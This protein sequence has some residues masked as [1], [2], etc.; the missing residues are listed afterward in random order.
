M[1]ATVRFLSTSGITT[2][3]AVAV[4][5]SD[6][7][8]LIQSSGLVEDYVSGNLSTYYHT[9]T[10]SAKPGIYTFTIAPAASVCPADFDIFI[11][12]TSTGDPVGVAEASFDDA[13]AE[14]TLSVLATLLASFLLA[15]LI[16][17]AHLQD[18]A[19][20]SATIQDVA[21][22]SATVSSEVCDQ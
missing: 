20:N 3:R 8:Y 19:V 4:R 2:L 10:E 17:C 1:S 7:K 14:V 21:L 15:V 9:P 5:R 12:D 16:G 18:V 22:Y 11:T 13:G 6:G